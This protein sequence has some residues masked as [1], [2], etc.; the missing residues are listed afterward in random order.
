MN[1]EQ[2]LLILR[3]SQSNMNEYGDEVVSNPTT[4]EGWKEIAASYSRGWNF[5]NVLGA[6]VGMHIRKRSP[7]NGGSQF[8][9]YKRYHSIVLLALV[10]ANH[11]FTWVQVGAPGAASDTQLWNESTLPDAVFTNSIDISEQEPLPVTNGPYSIS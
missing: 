5:H 6:L 10:D 4:A 8:C 1:N 2:R 9:D 3:L 11:S 7:A